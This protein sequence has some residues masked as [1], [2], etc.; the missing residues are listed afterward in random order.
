[1]AHK[2]GSLVTRRPGSPRWYE[3]FTVRGRRFRGSLG[4]DDREQA[5]IL[6]AHRR[7]EALLGHLVAAPPP[8]LTLSQA[9]GRYL[10]E[11]G[12]YLASAADIRRMGGALIAGLGRDRTLAEITPGDLAAY[13][14]RRRAGLSNRSVNAEI[15]HL[16]AV[17]RR[18]ASLWGAAVA[19]IAWQGLL[20]DEA[21]E[22][23]HVL[24]ADEETRL[25]A[26]LRPD[27][28]AMVRFALL[29]GVRLDNV[30]SLCWR[31]IDWN[32][33]T[34]VFRTKSRRPGGDL[35]YLPLTQAVTAILSAERG[36][37]RERVFTYVSRRDRFDPHSGKRQ[38][39]GERY[40]F[41]HDGWRKAWAAAL[42]AAGI[43]GF[44]FHDLRHTAGTRAL[45][46]YRNLKT[47]QRMLGHRSIASTLRYTRSDLDDVRAAMEA[48][49]TQ[50]GHSGRNAGRKSGT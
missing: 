20:L 1:M 46:A 5:E 18:A 7:R 26:A 32:A 47:V 2:R 24:S 44:R 25:F 33:R 4:T 30:V 45:Y 34:I 27:Y 48:V 43:E 12:Q 8:T 29:T 13:V 11:H 16:R 42:T 6:A 23:E 15:E 22:R 36:R 31:Q 10:M 21:G 37:H 38:T 9:L 41:T 50:F 17:M 35:Q 40:P 19:P 14:A 49:E 39:R 3:N 28:H